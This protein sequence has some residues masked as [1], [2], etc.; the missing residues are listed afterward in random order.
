MFSPKKGLNPRSPSKGSANSTPL[1]SGNSTPSKQSTTWN[2]ESS[3]PLDVNLETNVRSKS[4]QINKKI[5]HDE[6]TALEDA[7]EISRQTTEKRVQKAAQSKAFNEK[8]SRRAILAKEMMK[9][10]T[11]STSNKKKKGRDASEESL[12]T[13][14]TSSV[15]EKSF[16]SVPSVTSTSSSIKAKKNITKK[17]KEA[18]KKIKNSSSLKKEVTQTSNI[19]DTAKEEAASNARK[20]AA[21]RVYDASERMKKQELD[22][23]LAKNVKPVRKAYS[24]GRDR[25][26]SAPL[27][28]NKYNGSVSGMKPLLQ[29][30]KD[31]SASEH[32][33]KYIGVDQHDPMFPAIEAF[34]L[35]TPEHLR[36]VW[37]IKVPG[38]SLLAL[39]E[40]ICVLV[41]EEPGW[42]NSKKLLKRKD[43]IPSLAQA[44]EE[45]IPLTRIRM[46]R[47]R[48]YLAQAKNNQEF[49]LQKALLIWAQLI[50]GSERG[51]SN[52]KEHNQVKSELASV[53]V[54]A[55]ERAK[56][57][58][59]ESS[60]AATDNLSP[61]SVQEAVMALSKLTPEKVR[62]VATINDPTKAL[63]ALM[64]GICVLVGEEPGWVMAK[65]LL[66]RRDFI[67]A[68]ATANQ[69]N[70]PLARVRKL[71]NGGYLKRSIGVHKEGIVCE[72]LLLWTRAIYGDSGPI[73]EPRSQ[74]PVSSP[75]KT[76]I[77]PLKSGPQRVP[78]PTKKQQCQTPSPTK[79]GAD[80]PSPVPLVSDLA[81]N[82]FQEVRSSHESF[83]SE[84]N[85]RDRQGELLVSEEGHQEEE[86]GEESE[87]EGDLKNAEAQRIDDIGVFMKA[88]QAAKT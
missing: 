68:I 80:F 20:L 37:S 30:P 4:Y 27:P 82:I 60:F 33:S 59:R 41:G 15:L 66:N 36:E 25:P 9:T 78:S 29:N 10:S 5:F 85:D 13:S 67:P 45:H 63:I 40:G 71:R 49:D 32:G 46:F 52:D 64:E 3:S 38:P 31:G 83:H 54:A 74:A 70:I 77:N 35:L 47:S 23:E 16:E 8:T 86:K 34:S 88:M 22:R 1:K 19:D 39:L 79:G 18:V 56:I 17:S 69:E 48:N 24:E 65:K 84:Y 72:A 43:F 75:I 42:V 87:E 11:N 7:K 21:K 51:S 14:I 55:I 62:A 50:D 53:A 76:Q 61:P 44:T 6:D 28:R 12:N 2:L 81:K 58:Q 73:D 26:L 57:V